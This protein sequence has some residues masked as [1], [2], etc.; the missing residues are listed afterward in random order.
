MWNRLISDKANV[1]QNIY[2][3]TYANVK[4]S[5]PKPIQRVFFYLQIRLRWYTLSHQA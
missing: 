4:R 2:F 5:P 1:R 3:M